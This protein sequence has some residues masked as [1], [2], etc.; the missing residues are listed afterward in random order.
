MSISTRRGDEGQTDLMFGRRIS[1]SDLRVSTYGILDEVNS[2]LGLARVDATHPFVLERIAATQRDLVLVMGE[3]ATHE[4]DWASYRDRGRNTVDD[5]MLADLDGLV[6]TLE[7]EYGISF[8]R[9]AVPGAAGSRAGAALDVARTVV[10]H[11]ERAIV[12]LD[13]VGKLPNPLLLRWVNR[14]SDIFWLL[15]RLEE[16]AGPAA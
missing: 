1:K 13:E 7:H 11:A 14:L 9:W 16:Q 5:A 15:A 2:L 12:A 3:L 8:Q 6:H 10:R 4:E